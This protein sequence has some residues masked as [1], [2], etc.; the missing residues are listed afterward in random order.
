[1]IPEADFVQQA[2]EFFRSRVG[3]AA[4]PLTEDTELVASGIMDSL[5]VL[6]FFFFLEQLR[7]S[8]IEAEDFSVGAVSTLRKAYQLVAA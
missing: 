2:K 5:L 1:M 7:G 8:A 3:D 4:D 6:E